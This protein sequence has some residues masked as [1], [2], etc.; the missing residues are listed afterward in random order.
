ML[1][2]EALLTLTLLMILAVIWAIGMAPLRVF[3]VRPIVGNSPSEVFSSIY[4]EVSTKRKLTITGLSV[5]F[6]ASLG[7]AVSLLF[8]SDIRQALQLN[9]LY[10]SSIVLAF[11]SK[12][13]A[14][15]W[16]TRRISRSVFSFT[17]ILVTALCIFSAGYGILN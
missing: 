7:F 11:V 15:R 4:A 16:P 12:E 1:L 13:W 9:I 17:Y 14:I 6:S 2:S 5:V 8:V 3:V 10:A